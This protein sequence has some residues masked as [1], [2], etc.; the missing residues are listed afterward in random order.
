MGF[1]RF[2]RNVVNT[3]TG[4][5]TA[6]LIGGSSSYRENLG[7]LYLG[8]FGRSIDKSAPVGSIN[9]PTDQQLTTANLFRNLSPDQQR[10][11]LLNNPNIVTPGGSQNYDPITNT[12]SLNESNFQREQRLRQERLAEQLSSSLSGN[13]PSS[14]EEIQ[15]ATFERGR[16]LLDPTFEAQRRQLGQELADRG[17]PA[18]SE[19]YNLEMNRFEQSRNR[20]YTDLSQ[21]SI[22]TAEMQR[23]QRFNE[24]ASLLGTQ[25]LGGQNFQQ[26][27]PQFSGLDLFGAEQAGLNRQFQ[28]SALSQQLKQ[29]NRNAIY[30]ALG[31][32]G[33]AGIGA[34][35]ASDIKLKENIKK[36]GKENRFNIYEFNYISDPYSKYR[37]VMAQEVQ[38]IR[39]DAVIDK[40]GYLAVNYSKIGIE[41]KK[42]N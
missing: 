32:L 30:G 17:I 16:A 41:F 34:V 22:Q 5:L 18:G 15:N 42:I 31:N 20:A 13:L 23:Q 33:S 1:G 28:Q 10:D 8:D 38:K 11:L 27:Q 14:N 2:V 9:N 4:G 25:Q 29:S 3:A 35:A 24:I 6:P 36:V 37:G 39:P 26:Y 40:D 19:Q 7:S 12:I 21:A